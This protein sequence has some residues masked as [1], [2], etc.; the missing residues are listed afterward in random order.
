MIAIAIDDHAG[1]SIA[2]APDDAAKLQIDTSSRSVFGGLR[3]TAA[4]EVQ[5]EVLFPPRETSPH[6]LRFRVINRAADQMI[7][8]VFE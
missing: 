6:N 2:L 7:P 5:I 4:K 1:K 8:A 3:D